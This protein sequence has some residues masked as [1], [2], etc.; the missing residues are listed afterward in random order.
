MHT[1][2]LENWKMMFGRGRSIQFAGIV[3]RARNGLM[4]WLFI[5]HSFV[6]DECGERTSFLWM[7]FGGLS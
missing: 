6:A 5:I 1:N 3:T 2:L 7:T 4:A